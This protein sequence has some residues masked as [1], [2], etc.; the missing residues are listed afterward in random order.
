MAIKILDRHL[1]SAKGPSDDPYLLGYPDDDVKR[2]S[3]LPRGEKER[4]HAEVAKILAINQLPAMRLRRGPA[5][6]L[7]PLWPTQ[8]DDARRN[9]ILHQRRRY[10][11]EAA[12]HILNRY[13]KRQQ[14]LYKIYGTEQP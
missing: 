7:A 2:I 4:F 1:L 13:E 9:Y 8:I 10:G 5:T 6:Q 3:K 12:K 11:L 14:R